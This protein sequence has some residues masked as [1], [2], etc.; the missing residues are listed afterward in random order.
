M[1]AGGGGAQIIYSAAVGRQ[2]APQAVAVSPHDL[3]PLRQEHRSWL[4]S[5]LWDDDWAC[6]G[7]PAELVNRFLRHLDMRAR[8]VTLG[9]DAKPVS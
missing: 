7:G 9:Q 4:V 1:L 6:L 5:T 8:P 3:L 2:S